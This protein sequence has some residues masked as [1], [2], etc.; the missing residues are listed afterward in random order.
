MGSDQW[1]QNPIWR[2]DEDVSEL[3]EGD[4]GTIL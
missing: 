3:E 4:S 2:D 1:V